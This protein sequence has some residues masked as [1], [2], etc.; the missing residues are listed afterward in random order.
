[1]IKVSKTKAIQHNC[2]AWEI[3][4]TVQIEISTKKDTQF[5][6]Y[7]FW[8]ILFFSFAFCILFVQAFNN[9]LGYIN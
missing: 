8:Q 9:L 5:V 3:T 7:I 6:A 1:M 2:M 4:K